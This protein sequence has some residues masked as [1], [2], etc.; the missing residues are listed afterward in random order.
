MMEDIIKNT[1]MKKFPL[2][3][4]TATFRGDVL[5]GTQSQQ[6]IDGL[7]GAG[8][9]ADNIFVWGTSRFGSKYH[10]VTN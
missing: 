9:S 1:V 3:G 5:N 7:K 8:E 2:I 6:I 10:V 4:T